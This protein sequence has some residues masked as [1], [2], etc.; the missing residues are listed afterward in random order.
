M[1]QELFQGIKIGV[2]CFKNLFPCI[3]IYVPWFKKFCP[4]IKTDAP[5]FKILCPCTKIDD[6]WTIDNYY[7]VLILCLIIRLFC[8]YY[9]IMSLNAL[10]MMVAFIISSVATGSPS[11]WS[12]ASLVL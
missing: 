11:I 7:R 4:G 3:K 5:C 9:G 1:L 2:P 12:F 10:G 6:P 8:S